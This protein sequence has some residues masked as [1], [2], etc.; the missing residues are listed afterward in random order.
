[1]LQQLQEMA[2]SIF[3]YLVDSN[4]G[5]LSGFRLR[6]ASGKHHAQSTVCDLCQMTATDKEAVYVTAVLLTVFSRTSL[7][8]S[9]GR[10]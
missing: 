8:S 9:S 2:S 1:M 10:W 4:Q 3:F 6:K 7:L 5:R